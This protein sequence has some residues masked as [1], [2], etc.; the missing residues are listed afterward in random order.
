[1]PD[2]GV[3]DAVEEADEAS[4]GDVAAEDRVDLLAELRGARRFGREG[5]DR[6]L[7]VRHQQRRGNALADHVGDRQRERGCGEKRMASK[8]SPPTPEA[9]CHDAASSQPSICGSVAGS[10]VRWMRRASSSSRRSRCALR[11]PLAACVD[12]AAQQSPP[13]PRCPTASARSRA[14]RGAWPRPRGRPSPSRSS[15]RPA[16]CRRAPAGATAGRSLTARR[17]VAGVVQVHQQE[18]EPRPSARAARAAS[19]ECTASTCNALRLQQQAQRVDEVRLIVGDRE[20]GR[21]VTQVS[22]HD[23]GG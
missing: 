13:A 9:G 3:D 12:L 10:S 20:R 8:Q 2:F 23:C 22:R 21:A 17:R 5:A 18:V 4:F 15:R 11:A 14:R 16:A 6:G 1:M 19:G 7:Q